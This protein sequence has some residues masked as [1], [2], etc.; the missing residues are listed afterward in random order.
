MRIP[1]QT[2]KKQEIISGIIHIPENGIQKNVVIMCYGFNGCRSDVHRIAVKLGSFLEKRGIVLVRFDYR[3]QGNSQGDMNNVTIQ[4]RVDDVCTV[5]SFIQGCFNDSNLPISLIGFS[6]GAKIA[7]MV[8][9]YKKIKSLI[10]WNPIFGTRN[11]SYSRKEKGRMANA[12]FRNKKSGTLSYQYYGLPINIHYLNE[13]VDENSF[14][15]FEKND[16]HKFGVWGGDDLFTKGTRDSLI[17]MMDDY[18]IVPNAGHL[19]FGKECET[20]VF[21][22]TYRFIKKS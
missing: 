7:S 19:F 18:Y 8:T 20:L 1:F 6:D 15:Y 22:S 16:C 5:I 21:E 11:S 2:V 9:A 12:V 4:T 14:L 3:G 10:L 13:L 17:R